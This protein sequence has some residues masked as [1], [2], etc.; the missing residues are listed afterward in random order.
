MSDTATDRAQDERGATLVEYA[1]L[2][3]LIVVVSIGLIQRIESDGGSKLAASDDR[4]SAASDNAFYPGAT[5]S[6][7]PGSTTTTTSPTAVAVRI[8]SAPTITVANDGGNRWQATITFRLLDSAGNGVIGATLRGT[9]TD[10]GGGSN[11]QTTC[12]TSTTAGLCTIQ[13][14]D[15]KDNPSTSVTFTP[16]E[17]TGGSFTWVPSAPGEGTTVVNCSPPLTATC[18]NP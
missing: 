5:G 17:I 14:T 4:I 7:V 18:N 8:A 6:T 16:L 3:A 10:G 2:V 15:I 12:N 13:F 9:W 11:P 1:L